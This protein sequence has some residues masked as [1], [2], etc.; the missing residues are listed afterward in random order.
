VTVIV[1]KADFVMARYVQWNDH[2]PPPDWAKSIAAL[3]VWAVMLL[4][5]VVV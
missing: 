2:V 1:S 4:L 5:I 3:S